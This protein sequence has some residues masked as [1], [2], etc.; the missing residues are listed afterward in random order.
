M[1]I[2]RPSNETAEHRHARLHRIDELFRSR[3]LEYNAAYGLQSHYVSPPDDLPPRSAI[4]LLPIPVPTPAHIPFPA[5]A[6]APSPAPSLGLSSVTTLSTL[7]LIPLATSLSHGH[8]PSASSS[9]S[10]DPSSSTRVSTV[11]GDPN[12]SI[13]TTL[14]VH[15]PTLPPTPGT[16]QVCVSFSR[17]DGTSF[18]QLEFEGHTAMSISEL[19]ILTQQKLGFSFSTTQVVIHGQERQHHVLLGSFS[20]T[21]RRVGRISGDTGAR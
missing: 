6:P 10:S 12:S 16:F 1:S 4:P 18:T 2:S 20:L 7:P 8:T 14:G 13:S 3:R 19:I 15:Q 11:P 9:S 21:D 5:P 17:D